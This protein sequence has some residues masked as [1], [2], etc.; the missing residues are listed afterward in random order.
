MKKILR[1]KYGPENRY[2]VEFKDREPLDY[3]NAGTMRKLRY[4]V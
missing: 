3:V 2:R 4:L 1:V